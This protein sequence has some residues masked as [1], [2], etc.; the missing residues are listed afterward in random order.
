MP[1]RALVVTL[2]L[3][4]VTAALWLLHV[5][6]R[7]LPTGALVAAWLAMTAAMG[8]ALFRRA[9]IRRAAALGAYLRE[10]SAL[11][12][13]FRGGWLM[14]STRLALGAALALALLLAVLRLDDGRAWAALVA[15]A[16]V[17]GAAVL[18]LQQRLAAHANA[19]YLPELAWRLA[20]AAVGVVLVAVLVALAFHRAYPALGDATLEQAVWHMADAERA[21]SAFA[22]ALLQAAAAKD[23]LTLW[24]AQQLMP[25]PGASLA[26]ALGWLVVLGE[27]TLFVWS[28][29][30]LCSAWLLPITYSEADARTAS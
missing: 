1:H 18:W 30:T 16:P 27:E 24:L 29:L 10:G 19:V 20:A 7:T 21:R 3:L 4:A 25:E 2:A 26:D 8:F 17:L 22:Q 12:H 9:R 23:G 11:R 14:A 13:R 15:S 28:Y 5:F 6:G